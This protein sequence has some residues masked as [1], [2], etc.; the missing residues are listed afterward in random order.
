MKT[1]KY[2]TILIQIHSLNQCLKLKFNWNW[3]CIYSCSVLG[4][5]THLTEYFQQT[6]VASTLFIYLFIIFYLSVPGLSC[7]KQDR[8]CHLPGSLVG[9]MWD[10]VPWPGTEPGPLHWECRVLTTGPPGKSL[11]YSKVKK[12]RPRWK[13]FVFSVY[14]HCN[15][16][17]FLLKFSIL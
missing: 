12:L 3:F 2:F 13:V 6:Q 9:G 7:G 4:T 5:I 10:L 14:L 8:C 1:T 15:M 17:I 16:K 11:L